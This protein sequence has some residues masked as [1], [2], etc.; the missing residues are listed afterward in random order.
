[1][2]RVGVDRGARR[3]PSEIPP[4]RPVRNVRRVRYTCT[5]PALA[6][7]MP[8]SPDLVLV[9]GSSYVYRAFHALPPLTNSKGEPTG[10]VYGVLNM[11][12]KL[13]NDYNP[14]HIAVV[15]DPKGKTQ[16]SEYY[17]QYKATRP[18]MVDELSRQIKPLH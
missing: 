1:M 5:P 3:R 2:R 11:I 17:P 8:T 18:P 12:R 4:T 13:L 10:A 6:Y 7:P 14:E 15:F 16:R 9:D